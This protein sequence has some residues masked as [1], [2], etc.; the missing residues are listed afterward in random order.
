LHKNNY[1]LREPIYNLTVKITNK[2]ITDPNTDSYITSPDGFSS[3]ITVSFKDVY[4]TIDNTNFLTSLIGQKATVQVI[5]IK[6]NGLNTILDSK[7]KFHVR[8]PDEYLNARN[9]KV[10]GR[11]ALSSVAITRE[12]EYVT[13]YADTSGE[14]VFYKNDFPYWI[15]IVAGAVLILILSGIFTLILSPVRRRKRIPQGAR[16]MYELTENL[17]GDEAQYKWKVK[18]QI[19]EKKRRWK[20]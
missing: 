16:R 18:K 15:I 17:A 1:S 20:Y 11:G 19:E 7:V 4:D 12:G 9:L 5:T 3:N 2:V 13:F 10:E 8:I 14:I 6:E